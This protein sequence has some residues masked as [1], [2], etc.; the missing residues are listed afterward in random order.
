MLAY[1]GEINKAFFQDIYSWSTYNIIIIINLE[2][3]PSH[4][5]FI[6]SNG[7]LV[8]VLVSIGH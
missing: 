2:S 5:P 3:F 6:L 8:L 7:E 1:S 4:D